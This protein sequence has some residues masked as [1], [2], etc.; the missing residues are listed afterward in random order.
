MKG[1]AF[2]A[3]LVFSGTAALAET[4]PQTTTATYDTWQVRCQLGKTADGKDTKVCEVAQV[5]QIQGQAQPL[6]QIAVGRQA[7]G[8]AMKFVVQTPIGAWLAK[9]PQILVDDKSPPIATS[10]KRCLPQACYAE[11]DF[12]TDLESTF[13]SKGD[14]QGAIVF[15]MD[16]GKDIRVPMS[17]KGFSDAYAAMKATK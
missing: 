5:V 14:T 12:T 2:A 1:L 6:L 17:F 4:A 3:L 11:V 10:F 7:P 8:A 13:A 9:A 16:E 15:Q